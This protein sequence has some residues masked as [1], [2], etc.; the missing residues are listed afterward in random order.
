MVRLCQHCL[1]HRA[2]RR[3]Q[4]CSLCYACPSV[5]GRYMPYVAVPLQRGRRR[6]Y[7]P[8]HTKA[9]PGSP[10]KIEILKRRWEQG[11]ELFHPFDA[12]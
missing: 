1:Q 4:L 10:R 2:T 6:R 9:P 12:H 7:S 11:Y 5:R 8:Y 3:G